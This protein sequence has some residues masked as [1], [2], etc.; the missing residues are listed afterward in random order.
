MLGFALPEKAKLKSPA[1]VKH[2]LQM[3]LTS[4]KLGYL[5]CSVLY[6]TTVNDANI[7]G[8]L[9]KEPNQETLIIPCD[10]V[11]EHLGKETRDCMFSGITNG[12]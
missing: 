11:S 8:L 10:N 12:I 9:R 6:F 7:I 5:S 1:C 4:K 3:N 2:T